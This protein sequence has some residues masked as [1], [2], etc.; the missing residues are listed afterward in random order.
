MQDEGFVSPIRH[1]F[2]GKMYNFKHSPLMTLWTRKGE[3]A[4]GPGTAYPEVT[5]DQFN[6]LTPLMAQAMCGC[7]DGEPCACVGTGFRGQVYPEDQ[8]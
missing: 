8:A 5:V 7:F 4:F 3:F 6:A 1:E 2:Q